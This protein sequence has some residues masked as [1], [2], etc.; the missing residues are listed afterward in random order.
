[1][2]LKFWKT[3]LIPTSMLPIIM[4]LD[5]PE[6]TAKEAALIKEL[7]PAGFVLF[8]RNIISAIQTRDLTDTLRSLSR[9]TPIIA[10]DQEGGRVVR[11]SQLGLNLPSA[12]TL[13]LAGKAGKTNAI[14]DCASVIAR[15]LHW[16]GINLDFAPVL[17]ICHDESVSNALPG[18][19]WG[20]N[21]TDV[22][23]YAGMFNR[24]LSWF[25]MLGCGKHFPGM[26]RANNDPHHDLSVISASLDDLLRSDLQPFSALAQELPCLMTA[27]IL[28]PNI[29]PDYPTSLSSIITRQLLRNQL[30]Y[31]GIIITD[32]LCMGAICN[33]YGIPEAAIMALKA[34]SDL[35][36]ICHDATQRI[37]DFASL[38]YQTNIPDQQASL[39]RIEHL[40]NKLHLPP[41]ADDTT[42]QKCLIDAQTLC[43]QFP[44]QGTPLTSSPVQ[45][46]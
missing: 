20:N 40:I 34:S 18:R 17:D 39:T 32:D 23:S 25:G 13:A 22:I 16:L 41:P 31:N 3:K 33:T 14:V 4:G 38:L 5:G 15:A 26:G 35:P 21:V 30:G 11:T 42:W 8:S 45:L 46:M 12:R 29:D 10:I 36:L 6:P 19:C 7:Q 1:M 37:T 2:K 44:E 43:E 24:N 27:H 9:H 28:L